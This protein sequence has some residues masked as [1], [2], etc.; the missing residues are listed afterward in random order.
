MD[1]SPATDEMESRAAGALAPLSA[2]R[3]PA[4]LQARVFARVEEE[5]VLGRWRWVLAASA[6]GAFA[7]LVNGVVGVASS[8]GG[9]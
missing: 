1:Q 6:I 4:E 3:A 7:W 2:V 8:V 9:G 5:R